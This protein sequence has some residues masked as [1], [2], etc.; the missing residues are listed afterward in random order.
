MPRRGR[1]TAGGIVYH[2]LNRAA[3]RVPLF[4]NAADFSAFD[5][6]VA[7]AR[8]RVPISLFAY[9]VMPNH[10]HLI[11]CPPHDRDLSQFM[12]WLTMTH[13]QRW[14]AYR[15]TTGTGGVYQGRFKAIP[16]QSDHHFLGVCRYVERNA[17]RA[18]LV[19]DAR[20]WRWSSL[21]RRVNRRAQGVL[22]DWPI[23][24][25]ANWV[26]SV[27]QAQSESELQAIR[28]AISRGAPIGCPTWQADMARRLSLESSLRPRHRPKR[29]PVPLP[30]KG[31]RPPYP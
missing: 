2:V 19:A 5:Q 4:E 14:H 24:R 27:N 11:L 31:S 10:W 28:Q 30:E 13:A 16:I 6:L 22:D 7:E 12:H 1:T 26:D 20:D 17:L 8:L 3:K 9:C 21:W 23:S 18:G 29:A 25:P 15:G